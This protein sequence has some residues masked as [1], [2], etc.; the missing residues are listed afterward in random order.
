MKGGL[1]YKDLDELKRKAALLDEAVAYM[2]GR[3]DSEDLAVVDAILTRRAP[4]RK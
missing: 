2:T 3:I 4:E 1:T